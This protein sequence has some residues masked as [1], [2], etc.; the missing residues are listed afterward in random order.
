VCQVK[1]VEGGNKE[2]TTLIKSCIISPPNFGSYKY[3]RDICPYT[4]R[5]LSDNKT[6]LSG[7]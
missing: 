6:T 7:G 2:E 1:E 3:K 4:A 5:V